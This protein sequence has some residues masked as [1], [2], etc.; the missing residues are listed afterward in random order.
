MNAHRRL[1][2]RRRRWAL[3]KTVDTIHEAP[4]PYIDSLGVLMRE[5][6]TTQDYQHLRGRCGSST[7]H[8]SRTG[9]WRVVLH[10]PSA[11]AVRWAASRER[12]RLQQLDA[13]VDL[14]AATWCEAEA[15]A[16]RAQQMILHRRR[17][18]PGGRYEQTWYSTRGAWGGVGIAIY[19]NRPHQRNRN[20][21][22]CHIEVRLRGTEACKR[23][24]LILR[25][26][27][28]L[29]LEEL[30]SRYIGWATIDHAALGRHILAH[31]LY[32][33]PSEDHVHIGERTASLIGRGAGYVGSA[34]QA[35]IDYLR[36][37]QH[38]HPQRIVQPSNG[39]RS[40]AATSTTNTT[41]S[42]HPAERRRRVRL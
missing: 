14:P 11:D 27:P 17:R 8:R 25:R 41:S 16:D 37:I 1:F 12:T 35:V 28:I 18:K 6:P 38:P 26:L 4:P 39:Y 9:D 20:A 19:G 2:G 3:E 21:P 24:G 5:R 22:C 40:F 42:P 7:T 15:L 30:M 36:L 29:D 31:G 23:A 34:V 10:Q 13:A 32:S 33:S